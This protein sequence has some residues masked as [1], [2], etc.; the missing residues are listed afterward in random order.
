[1]KITKKNKFSEKLK[2][3]NFKKLNFQ[4]IKISKN[5]ILG[6]WTC[7]FFLHRKSVSWIPR[8]C[9]HEGARQASG[10]ANQMAASRKD[11]KRGTEL[12]RHSQGTYC[13]RSKCSPVEGGIFLFKF[14]RFFFKIFLFSSSEFLQI[15]RLIFFH[16]R[17]SNFPRKGGILAFLEVATS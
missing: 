8:I 14:H 17:F 5:I 16:F 1:M 11:A 13:S 12:W 4:K 7:L 6:A 9:P 2:F 3:Q 15:F 10:R